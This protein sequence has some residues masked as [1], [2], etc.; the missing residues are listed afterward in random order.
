MDE[1]KTSDINKTK[2]VLEDKGKK[3]IRLAEE[4]GKSYS[5]INAYVQNKQQPRREILMS[6]AEITDIN[7]KE[8]IISNNESK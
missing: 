5:V 8:L 7:V 1:K 3:Q 2:G 6:I 4:L